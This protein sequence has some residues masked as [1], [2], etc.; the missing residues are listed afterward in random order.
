M[1]KYIIVFLSL[2]AI[3][4]GCA[5]AKKSKSASGTQSSVIAQNIDVPE[6]NADSAWTYINN[7]VM[8][9]PR[10]PNTQAHK[11]CAKYL[12]EY[13]TNLGADVIEQKTRV[14]TYNNETLNIV[15]IIA[16]FDL[17]NK[18]RIILCAH[19]DTRPFADQE[20]IS[21][22]WNTP[23]DG[24]NDGGSGVGVLME[25]GRHISKNPT[26]VGIDI[27]LFDGEIGRASCRERV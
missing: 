7:Q 13:F 3:I 22:L 25:I 21:S 14:K 20:A 26:D 10:V 15:N 6:F 1:K 27:I 18:N 11:N 24:A 2:A 19:W 5:D 16:Q 23:I 17:E 9:G 8:F 12:S 4:A